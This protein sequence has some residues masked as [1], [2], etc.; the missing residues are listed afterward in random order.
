MSGSLAERVNINAYLILSFFITGWI[1]PVI[2]HW[3]WGEGWLFQLGY[4]DF[5]GSGIVHLTGGMIGLAAAIICGPR[6]GKFKPIREGGDTQVR[7]DEKIVGSDE[8]DADIESKVE[9]VGPVQ[10]KLSY[11]DIIKKFHAREINIDHVH[12][13][14][15]KY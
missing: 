8:A 7:K 10:R 15:R 5:A 1:Y 9:E 14:V 11:G 3:T 2:V 12:E 13:F 4:Y 6:L